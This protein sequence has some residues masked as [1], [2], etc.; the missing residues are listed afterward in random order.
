MR[1]IENANESSSQK[2]KIKQNAC[3]F[4]LFDL[5]DWLANESMLILGL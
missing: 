4:I 2:N 5:S 3:L 1:F